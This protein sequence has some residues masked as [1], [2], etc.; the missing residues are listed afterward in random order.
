[1]ASNSALAIGE[2]RLMTSK[3][4]PDY[5]QDDGQSALR[6]R[7]SW[8]EREMGVKDSFF[9]RHLRVSEELFHGWRG[10]T[11]ESLPAEREKNLRDLW[12]TMLHL[13]SFLN[14][15]EQKVRVFIR[16]S[17]PTEDTDTRKSPLLPPWVGRSLIAFLEERGPDALPEVDRWI[18]S[19]RFGDAH[20]F[21]EEQT[22][23]P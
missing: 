7:V 12:K 5:F 2:D 17:I 11:H 13:L 22:S 23:C 21:R 20:T 19:L 6:E 4:V 1:M 10:R 8:F 3:Y 14:F 15:D 18:S 9:A 16:F